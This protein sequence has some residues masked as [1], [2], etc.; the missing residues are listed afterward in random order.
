MGLTPSRGA[1]KHYDRLADAHFGETPVPLSPS[2]VASS[3]ERLEAEYRSSRIGLKAAGND[4]LRNW[5]SGIER[6]DQSSL[7]DLY[8][9]IE[10]ANMVIKSVMQARADLAATRPQR[11]ASW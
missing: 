2:K 10:A 6:Y 8:G 5:M 3:L 1:K 9:R 11:P 4:W 7:V